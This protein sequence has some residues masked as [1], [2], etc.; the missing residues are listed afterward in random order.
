M[1]CSMLC[2]LLFYNSFSSLHGSSAGKGDQQESFGDK[3]TS[4]S[5]GVAGPRRSRL[6]ASGS[7]ED[8]QLAQSQPGKETNSA[9]HPR[10]QPPSVRPA[11]DA[12]SVTQH[13]ARTC[14]LPWLGQAFPLSLSLS[15]GLSL[16][17]FES[18]DDETEVLS[19]LHTHVALFVHGTRAN[20][21]GFSTEERWSGSAS[22]WPSSVIKMKTRLDG[23]HGNKYREEKASELL[24]L[25]SYLSL[26]F[27]SK[28]S[29]V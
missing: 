15:L 1:I 3:S 8:V 22:W 9:P 23:V 6:E 20:S 21:A 26:T 14:S 18:R 5:L 27:S 4:G 19:S 17:Y 12:V 7:S 29:R 25:T 10:L 11:Q 28:E 2:K 24:Q 13:E 16:P